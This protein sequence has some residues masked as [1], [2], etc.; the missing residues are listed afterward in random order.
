M[1][2]KSSRRNFV[3]RSAAAVVGA[4]VLPHIIPSQASGMGGKVAPGNRIVTG[5]NGGQT[6]FYQEKELVHVYP[7]PIGEPLSKD[8][9]VTVE[10]KKVPV[11]L[12][13]VCS[14]TTKERQS[15]DNSGSGPEDDPNWGTGLTAF[16]SFDIQDKVEVSVTMPYNAYI[17][18]AKI[19][20]SSSGIILA[21]TGNTIKFTI[22]KSGQYVLETNDNQ[23]NSL[24]IF[25]N[26]F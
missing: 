14:L 15:L 8:F 21:I 5:Q 9:K 7:A 18:S 26:P 11:Y 16:A 23:V 10:N 22:P 17:Q 25:S 4:F 19:L 12:A 13:R 6:P 24:Q 2:K 1:A 20:P 3:K